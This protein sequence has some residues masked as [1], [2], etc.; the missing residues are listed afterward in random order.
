[1]ELWGV[2]RLQLELTS[3]SLSLHG[4]RLISCGAFE[5]QAIS[6]AGSPLEQTTPN[7]E[8]MNIIETK[9]Q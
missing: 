7:L 8:K 6:L 5:V 1:M 3:T 9:T 2:Y 4:L